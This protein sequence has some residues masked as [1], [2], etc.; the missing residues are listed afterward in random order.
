MRV[1][2]SILIFLAIL[3]PVISG[4]RWVFDTSSGL[5]IIPLLLFFLIDRDRD[6]YAL[7]LG[8][9][10]GICAGFLSAGPAALWILQYVGE[11]WVIGRLLRAGIRSGY[12]RFI[13]VWVVMGVDFGA[14]LLLRTVLDYPLKTQLLEDWLVMDGIVAGIG[15][16]VL[17]LGRVSGMSGNLPSP[18]QHG[19]GIP[20]V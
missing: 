20:V 13:L 5:N 19:I 14:G 4:F 15:M 10:A 3:V 12:M 11:A 6:L 17:L 2:R 18:K 7:I 9:V 1:L 8:G 16:L